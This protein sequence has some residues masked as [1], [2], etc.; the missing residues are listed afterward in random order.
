MVN[1]M[2]KRVSTTKRQIMFFFYILLRY[3]KLKESNR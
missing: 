3:I 2:A 1:V